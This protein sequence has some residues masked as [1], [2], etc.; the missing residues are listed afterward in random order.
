MSLPGLVRWAKFASTAWYYFVRGK[1][2]ACITLPA[3][4]PVLTSCISSPHHLHSFSSKQKSQLSPMNISLSITKGRKML[5]V[6]LKKNTS[7]LKKKDTV[8]GLAA[9][10]SEGWGGENRVAGLPSHSADG[11]HWVPFQSF[12]FHVGV[13]HKI[14]N[15][16]WM[17]LMFSLPNFKCFRE[18]QWIFTSLSFDI[19]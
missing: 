12:F 19:G 6:S 18:E 16:Q 3:A 9:A 15:S 8:R 14:Q 17:F 10:L 4:N 5:S 1:V 2:G 13:N 7:T 11:T